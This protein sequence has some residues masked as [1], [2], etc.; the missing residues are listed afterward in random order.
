MQ[1]RR[2]ERTAWVV[3]LLNVLYGVADSFCS[4]FV[5]VYLWVNSLDFQVVCRHYV[6]LYLTMAVTFLFAGWY[7]QARDRVH[8]FRLG[9]ALHV[10]YYGALLFLREHAPDHAV[11]LGMLFGV[12]SALYWTGNHTFNFDV[13][14][15]RQR[16]YF[17]GWMGAA[18]G[19]ARML[20]PLFSGLIIRSA[21]AAHQGYLWVFAGAA[22]VYAAAIVVSGWMPSDSEPRPFHLRRALFP[23][24]DQREWQWMMLVSA[25]LAG[26]YGIFDFILGLLMFMHTSSEMSVGGFSSLQATAGIVVSYALGRFIVPKTRR[27]SMFWSTILM[28]AAGVLVVF[29]L[30]LF[31][32]IIFGFLRSI[33]S[34]LFNVPYASIRF[35]AIERC[36][37][38]P[39]QRIEYLCAWEVPL[40]TGRVMIMLLMALLF[41]CFGEMGIRATL[42]IICANRFL[43]YYLV[44]RVPGV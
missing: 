21:P 6:A 33:A 36:V 38:S 16:D 11:G 43:T 5:G 20:A 29:R 26:I 32:L 24:K 35:D 28:F 14:T 39:S 27:L 13:V 4:I 40:A 31:T 18:T 12:T 42:F 1:E 19:I 3:I 44:T 9:L 25:S 17:F 22:A 23:G 30:N 7:A 37:Q 8:V 34:P 2:L 15:A 41:A 10:V